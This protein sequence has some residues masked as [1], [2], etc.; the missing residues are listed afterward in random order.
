MTRRTITVAALAIFAAMLV[1]CGKN[2]TTQ[3]GAS[4]STSAGPTASS[5]VQLNG[6]VS[7]KGT[8]DIASAGASPTVEVEMNENYF[9]PTF[10]KAAPGA[11]VT[12]QLKNEGQKSHTFTLT[13]GKVDQTFEKGKSG[14]VK[15]T[16]PQS[17]TVAFYCKFHRATGM[18]GGLFTGEGGA[19]GVT[20]TTPKAAST[21]SGA[22]GAGGYGY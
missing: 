8:K 6:Q 12:L 5:P 15:V 22:G 9:S 13:D 18:Q 7:D 17:G 21:S 1:G 14:E 19:G 4:N 20:P 10:I 16:V 2:D 11:E 3:T